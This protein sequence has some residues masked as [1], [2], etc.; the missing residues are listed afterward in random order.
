MLTLS[1][2][3]LCYS[4]GGGGKLYMFCTTAVYPPLPELVTALLYSR[5]Y[6][7]KNILKVE[8]VLRSVVCRLR[9]M[10]SLLNLDVCAKRVIPL[11]T[12][13]LLSIV[14]P[15]ARANHLPFS[16]C[17][18]KQDR[19][20]AGSYG[21]IIFTPFPLRSIL[22]IAPKEVNE[23]CSIAG[24]ETCPKTCQLVHY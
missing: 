2:A 21:P 11:Y 22:S 17:S 15:T 19:G 14:C 24:A 4:V 3:S 1:I 10:I 12:I 5:R 6:R 16:N 18:I 7:C 13:I 8:H 9:S 23:C 20:S